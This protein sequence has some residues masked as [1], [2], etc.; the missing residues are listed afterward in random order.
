MATE[1]FLLPILEEVQTI[2]RSTLNTE[3]DLIDSNLTDISDDWILI[4]NY[5][6]FPEFTPMIQIWPVPEEHIVSS[7]DFGGD[8]IAPKFRFTTIVTVEHKDDLTRL[9]ALD[10]YITAIG[11]SVVK[12]TSGEPWTLNG[13]CEVLTWDSIPYGNVFTNRE[14]SALMQSGGIIWTAEKEFNIV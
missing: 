12:G 6:L 11:H 4:E 13:E 10:K 2:L 5:E 3:L 8:L 14:E 9:T 1:G 7:G